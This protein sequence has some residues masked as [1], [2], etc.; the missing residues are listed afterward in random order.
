MKEFL[1]DFAQEAKYIAPRAALIATAVIAVTDLASPLVGG[2]SDIMK[3]AD[4]LMGKTAHAQTVKA[5]PDMMYPAQL[6]HACLTEGAAAAVA[7][8]NNGQFL[9]SNASA[10]MK[11]AVIE[12][13]QRKLA[14][15]DVGDD[16]I[17]TA[18]DD[19]TEIGFDQGA[20]G[21]WTPE[22]FAGA[23]LALSV[24]SSEFSA[25]RMMAEGQGSVIAA[26]RAFNGNNL[27]GASDETVMVSLK[28]KAFT[29]NVIETGQL[30]DSAENAV[31]R[32][33]GLNLA[34]TGYDKVVPTKAYR[35]T[36][37]SVDDSIVEAQRRSTFGD[38]Q[39]TVKRGYTY[40]DAY[41][42]NQ[43][44]VVKI[45]LMGRVM[46]ADVIGAL[47][48]SIAKDEEKGLSPRA[49]ENFPSIDTL[50]AFSEPDPFDL[51]EDVAV[52]PAAMEDLVVRFSGDM[53]PGEVARLIEVIKQKMDAAAPAADPFGLEDASPEALYAI[54]EIMASQEVDIEEE[55]TLPA[56]D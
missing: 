21:K 40:N 6:L 48:D 29:R 19:I 12:T 52:E 31:Q 25:M 35:F 51:E 50:G 46:P 49:L 23:Y 53:A 39:E 34:V 43:K 27:D 1:K 38:Y 14:S 2:Q 4:A 15:Y 17:K 13:A 55:N 9:P 44:D 11:S 18:C 20:A 32:L 16:I 22:D 10:E 41:L 42:V 8:N 28:A 24:G 3:T 26:D 30:L 45:E 5:K 56:F 7:L 36:E 33:E 54:G 37:V 47:Q